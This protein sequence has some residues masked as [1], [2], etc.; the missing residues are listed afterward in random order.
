MTTTIQA[1]DLQ[2]GMLFGIFNFF[3]ID[4][5]RQVSN[6]DVYYKS[7]SKTVRCNSKQEIRVTIVK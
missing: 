2:V 5:V 3:R 1:K 6:G 7:G 4:A